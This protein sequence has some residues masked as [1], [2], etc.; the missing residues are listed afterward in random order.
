MNSTAKFASDYIDREGRICH[1]VVKTY[2]GKIVSIT[3]YVPGFEIINGEAV[4]VFRAYKKDY[5]DSD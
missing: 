4:E 5:Y 3:D 2:L 1:K